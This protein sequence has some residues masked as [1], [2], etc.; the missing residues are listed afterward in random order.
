MY[1]V[2][3]SMGK[4]DAQPYQGDVVTIDGT[5]PVTVPLA[6]SSELNYSNPA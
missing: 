3:K 4:E 1:V 2:G 6:A 5:V